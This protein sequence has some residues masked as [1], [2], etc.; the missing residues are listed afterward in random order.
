ME[1]IQLPGGDRTSNL[2]MG[3]GRLMGA[4]TLRE[5]LG[6]LE[7]AFDAGIRHFDTAP[8][9]GSGQSEGCLGEFLSRHRNTVTIT[10]KYGIAPPEHP[11]L[12]TVALGLVRP[13]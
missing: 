13:L 1:V 5:S 11:G 2:G 9:Y 8:S 3:T 7:A 6:L 4:T 10:T 12:I